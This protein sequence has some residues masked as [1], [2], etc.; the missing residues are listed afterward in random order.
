MNEI[1]GDWGVKCLDYLFGCIDLG[2][3]SISLHVVMLGFVE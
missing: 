3:I 2:S 1:D